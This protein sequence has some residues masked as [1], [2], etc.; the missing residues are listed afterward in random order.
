MVGHTKRHCG[1]SAGDDIRHH[2]LAI[3][4]H[5]QRSRPELLR[6]I[7]GLRRDILGYAVEAFG[8]VQEE[9]D[10]LGQG[11]LLGSVDL[12]HGFR[13]E[14]VGPQSIDSIGGKGHQAA[15]FQQPAGLLN[16]MCVCG[17][18]DL[19]THVP[20]PGYS[21]LGGD[22]CHPVETCQVLDQGDGGSRELL[23][24]QFVDG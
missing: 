7:P 21:P 16:C 2:R 3:E 18:N 12:L 15:C 9:G 22:D 14:G 6:Q 4:N 24:C 17:C 1:S 23:S 11:P 13:Q 10:G 5:G 20:S 19:S 8:A